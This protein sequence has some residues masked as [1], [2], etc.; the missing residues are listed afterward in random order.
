MSTNEFICKLAKMSGKADSKAFYRI[1]ECAMTVEEAR[2]LLELP[3]PNAD[4]AAKFNLD[5]KAVEDKILGLAQRGLVTVSRK[6][7]RYPRDPGTLHDNMLSSAP[8]HI[9]P[10][11][12]KIWMELY[13]D[14]E[15]WRVAARVLG[16]TGNI[17][18]RVIPARRSVPNHVKLLPYENVVDI[19]QAHKDLISVRRCCCRVGAKKCDHPNEVCIQFGRRAEY[20]LFR[21]SGRKISADE[22][23]ALSLMAEESGLVPMVTNLSVTERLEFICYCCGCCCVVLN[24]GLRANTIDKI[25]APSRFLAKVDDEKCS[26]CGDCVPR[27][28]FNAIEMTDRPHFDKAWIVID[29]GKCIGCG[30]CGLV[31]ELEAITQEMVRPP[32]FVPETISGPSV[33][34]H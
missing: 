13:E 10:G 14:E 34:L 7:Y 3:V 15:W 31:C 28:Y 19:V 12:E 21:S 25:L 17:F 24:P 6:G 26:G 22:A 5:E 2:F 32:E 16:S 20:D 27:C 11:I 18:L 29:E 9:P 30:L 8:Q 23:I 1:L 4:L 33:V